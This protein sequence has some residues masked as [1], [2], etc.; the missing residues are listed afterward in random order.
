MDGFDGFDEFN[1]RDAYEATETHLK[2]AAQWVEK[3]RGVA[4]PILLYLTQGVKMFESYGMNEEK[5]VVES[6]RDGLV[7]FLEEGTE[8]LL[9]LQSDIVNIMQAE[10]RYL[11]VLRELMQKSVK[12]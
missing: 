10:V 11:E 2:R 6:Q 5:M 7:N 9:S 3:I 12:K 1:N 8:I 4:G